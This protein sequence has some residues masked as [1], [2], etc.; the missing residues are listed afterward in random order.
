MPLQCFCL[1]VFCS[2]LPRSFGLNSDSCIDLSSI[3]G[4]IWWSSS[5][6]TIEL[7]EYWISKWLHFHGKRLLA[8]IIAFP[9]KIGCTEQQQRHLSFHIRD[10]NVLRPAN[11]NSISQQYFST[12][13]LNCISELYSSTVFLNSI[14][15]LYFSTVFLNCNYQQY[16]STVFVNSFCQ[17]YLSKIFVNSIFQQ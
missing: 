1:C 7:L 3:G 5:Y 16:F 12:V 4:I 6:I 10:L 2:S 14:F 17:P 15:Q 9:W 11:F 13:F 8:Q